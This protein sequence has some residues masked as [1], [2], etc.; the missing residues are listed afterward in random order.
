[1]Y[2]ERAANRQK[3]GENRGRQ[4]PNPE[5][6]LTAERFGEFIGTPVNGV[7]LYYKN[8]GKKHQQRT[9]TDGY[10]LLKELVWETRILLKVNTTVLM[11]QRKTTLI[12]LQ[13][14][15][16]IYYKYWFIKSRSTSWSQ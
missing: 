7:C 9:T 2:R 16:Q 4:E 15:K 8:S 3:A 1:M 14:G 11:E 6:V 13:Q 5:D 12:L 10:N